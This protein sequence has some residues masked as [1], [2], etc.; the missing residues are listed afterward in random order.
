[1][2][3][4]SAQAVTTVDGEL[5]RSLRIGWLGGPASSYWFTRFVLLR[6]IGFIYSVAFLVLVQQGPGLIGSRGLLPA[7]PFLARVW[8][9]I[10]F[11]KL[12][13]LFF[14]DAS[15]AALRLCSWLGLA[16][17]L[18]VL[19]GAE[20]AVV[21]AALWAL[22]MSFCH[23]GQTFWGYGWE[24]LLLEVGFLSIFLCPV[25]SLLPLRSRVAPSSIVIWLLRWVVFRLMFGAGMIKIRGDSCWTD[26]T[27]LAYHYETQP[28]PNPLSRLLHQAPLGFHRAGVAFNHFVELFVPWFVFGPRRVRHVAGALIVGF[29][30]FL[31]F[32][33]NLSFL[34]WLTIAVT[35][36][37]FDD[38]VLKALMPRRVLARVSV[39][40]AQRTQSRAQQWT[41]AVLAALVLV[42]SYAP[43]ANLLSPHQ[44]MNTSFDPFHL[45]NSYGAF[46]S[47]GR[48]R[49]EVIIEGTRD[50]VL[51]PNTQWQAYEFP[52][53]PG[54]VRRRPCVIT[55]YHYRLDWQMWFAA[56]GN[57]SREP[58]I[59]NLAYKLLRAEPT[60]RALLAHDPFGKMP[61]RYVRA[62]RYRYRFTRLGDPSGDWWTRTRVGPYLPT[63]SLT[64]PGLREF[65]EAHGWSWDE[66]GR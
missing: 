11:W 3:D 56:L 9:A 39:L 30:T 21:M 42:L 55:P 36:S 60:V 14:F 52:C 27:C 65:I 54:D 10:G 48:E 13:T 64:H 66:A 63:L 58:W 59:V 25:T 35:L 41:T 7:A 45:V 43:I 28:V 2:T 26:L 29:Q 61:P 53:K 34:N 23:S 62:D 24:I 15:D 32:S 20:N 8:P 57:V 12:P 4:A 46:G 5:V 40:Q 22:Y 44:A 16:L 33:G 47:I 37:C 1:V 17:S 18:A 51:G 6:A 31:I 50:A 38:S 49:D 19:L